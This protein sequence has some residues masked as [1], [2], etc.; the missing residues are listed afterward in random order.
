ML[1]EF[2][3]DRRG[4]G[5]VQG[6]REEVSRVAG[7]ME[8]FGRFGEFVIILGRIMEGVV[9][10]GGGICENSKYLSQRRFIFCFGFYR[11][12]IEVGIIGRGRCVFYGVSVFNGLVRNLIGGLVQRLQGYLRKVYERDRGSYGQIIVFKDMVLIFVFFCLLVLGDFDKLRNFLK[13]DGWGCGLGEG[14]CQ[15][16]LFFFYYIVDRYLRIFFFKFVFCWFRVKCVV[17]L[18]GL[19]RKWFGLDLK[20]IDLF[21]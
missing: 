11:F 6:E 7:E 9:G 1:R 5:R 18:L 3:R 21:F 2:F 20:Q 8:T 16:S 14:F 19:A 15:A 4:E 13:S 17:F 10:L 12:F